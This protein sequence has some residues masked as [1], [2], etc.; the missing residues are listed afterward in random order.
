MFVEGRKL[1]VYDKGR[2]EI[3]SRNNYFSDTKFDTFDKPVVL[4]VN[5]FSASASEIVSGAL[6]HYKRATLIGEKTYGKGS[7]QVVFWVAST[8]FSCQ[9]K[10]TIAK[11]YLPNDNCIHGV[12][13][14]PDMPVEPQ[15]IQGWVFDEQGRLREAGILSAYVD[16]I[17][18]EHREIAFELA[19][20]DYGDYTRYPDFELW[21][22]SVDTIL[23]RDM[24]RYIL[25]DELRRVVQDEKG[26]E[27]PCD[28][29]SDVQLQK[30]IIE[31]VRKT[32]RDPAQVE[33]IA[34]FVKI[35]KEREQAA[36]DE[37]RQRDKLFEDKPENAAD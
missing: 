34:P 24:L 20:N 21:A 22:D 32:G 25:H 26:K 17:M 18:A 10:L 1:V 13:I 3:R 14:E 4:L 23:D 6:K 11:Y 2:P 30:A 37:K 33:D 35:V 28:P 27:F 7:V 29:G 5:G 12:G 8:D 19:A 16:K 9:L 36:V 15:E 31:L